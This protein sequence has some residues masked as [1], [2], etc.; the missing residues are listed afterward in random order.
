MKKGAGVA[1]IFGL[2][3]VILVVVVFA[4]GV[5]SHYNAQTSIV[6]KAVEVYDTIHTAE[7]VKRTLD[8]ACGVNAELATR[9]L[10]VGGGIPV[11]TNE[12]PKMEQ[13]VKELEKEIEKEMNHIDFNGLSGREISWELSKVSVKEYTDDYFVISGNKS[14]TV[15]SKISTPQVEIENQGAFECKVK[16]S[17]FKLL[18]VGLSSAQCPPAEGE[19]T[20]EGLERNITAKGENIYSVR[21]FDESSNFELRFTLNCTAE[22]PSES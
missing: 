5:V 1:W 13:L 12:T 15:E 2:M 14:F 7:F 22:K 21:I 11:W 8:G 17:Y 19:M 6:S 3:M 20:I 10:M 4:T 18:R 9:A 16:S